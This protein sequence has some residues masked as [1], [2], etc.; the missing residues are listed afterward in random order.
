MKIGY[1][2]KSKIWSLRKLR[3]KKRNFETKKVKLPLQRAKE[4]QKITLQIER[5]EVK[6]SLILLQ[7]NQNLIKEPHQLTTLSIMDY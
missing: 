7:L 4:R 2:F 5:V 3:N 6:V 1:R